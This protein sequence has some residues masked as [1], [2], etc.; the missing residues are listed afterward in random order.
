M[1]IEPGRVHAPNTNKAD[2]SGEGSA[3]EN[4]GNRGGSCVEK[5]PIGLDFIR[6]NRLLLKIEDRPLSGTGEGRD[7]EERW[8]VVPENPGARV[9]KG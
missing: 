8:T 9:Q 4:L 1:A 7:F 3:F 5:C 6:H 2:P